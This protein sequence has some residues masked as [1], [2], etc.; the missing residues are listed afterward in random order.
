MV[1]NCLLNSLW[2]NADVPLGCGCG[3]VLQQS[4]DKGN[5]ETVIVVDFR[6]VPLTEAVG[7]DAINVQIVADDFQLLLD[8]PFRNRENQFIA[9]DAVAQTVVLNVL[10]NDKGN[11]EESALACLLLHHFQTVAVCIPYDIARAQF[12]NVADAQA[13]VPFQHKGGCDALIGAAA[14]EALLHGLDDFGVSQSINT[15]LKN[16]TVNRLT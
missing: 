10:L 7:A 14:A 15:N 8:C 11:C 2:F 3:T 13:Q 4:L 12:Q 1:L 5:V 16:I 6:C 9:P